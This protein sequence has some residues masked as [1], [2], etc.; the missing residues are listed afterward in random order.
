MTATPTCEAQPQSS[1]LT[2]GTPR[3]ASRTLRLPHDPSAAASARRSA[4]EL[5]VTWGLGQD[6]VDNALLVVT[7]LVTN[8][9]QHAQPPVRLRLS[10]ADSAPFGVEIDVADGGPAPAPAGTDEADAPAETALAEHGR[11]TLIVATLAEHHGTRNAAGATHHWA[12]L[13]APEPI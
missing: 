10:A 6:C 9:V 1:L 8:A 7:E 4:R 12:T 3:R 11:G 2:S 5:F 13:V